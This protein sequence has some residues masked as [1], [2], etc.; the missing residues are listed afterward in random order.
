MKSLQK[1]KSDAKTVEKICMMSFLVQVNI[2]AEEDLIDIWASIS[3]HNSVVA[4]KFVRVLGL[5]ID[6][7]FEMPERGAM[8]D[9]VKK[10][11]TNACRR[12]ISHFLRGV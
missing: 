9:D 11:N 4:D 5:R 8:R 6:S 1:Q 10:G 7:L 2:E 12:K 3:V